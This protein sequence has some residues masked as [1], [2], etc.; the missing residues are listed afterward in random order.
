MT[1][2]QS[3][4]LVS[5]FNGMKNV[6]NLDYVCAWYKKACEYIQG[7][8]IRCAFVSTN[9]I[10]QGQQVPIIWKE[11]F[12]KGVHINFAHQTFKWSNEA[13]GKAMV[14][15]IIVG[16][17]LRDEKE[18][19]LFI[20]EDIKGE[21]K[22]IKAKQINAYLMDAEN[23]FIESRNKAIVSDIPAMV[24][25]N[26][27]N[28]GGHLIIEENEYEA[29]IKAEP[30]AKKFIRKLLGAE[31]FINN[32]RRYCLW[33]V[34]AKPEELK[35]CPKIMERIAKVKE[36]REKSTRQA[37]RK[38]SAFPSLFGEIRQPEGV[39]YLL[40]PSATSDKRKYIPIGF[41]DG[42]VIASNLNLIIPHANLYHF[43][44]LTSQMHMAWTKTVCGRL[45]TGYRYSKD[46]VYNNFPWVMASHAQQEAIAQKTKAVLEARAKYPESSLA[47]LY[48]PLTMPKD[49]VKAHKTLD[50]A[51]D[52]L[53]RETPF[54]DDAE[55]VSFLFEMYKEI[56]KRK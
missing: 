43:G 52:K 56:M 12:A 18:K 41:I 8:E 32:K 6:G 9:S 1:K 46:V 19:T 11:M 44:V 29:F 47:D 37:T 45:G 5:I 53:Y 36:H 51:V 30:Q 50:L 33:L 22:A 42:I 10:C 20:Y 16:F 14:Y 48:D 23:V 38:L 49:L 2:E 15:C 26:M 40:I 3:L 34:G 39:D 31:E 24:F 27:P 17:S 21:P 25:G 28:D 55:R 13:R 35:A 54:K 7:T 4:E